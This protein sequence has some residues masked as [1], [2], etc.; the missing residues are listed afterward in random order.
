MHASQNERRTRTPSSFGKGLS[1][2]LCPNTERKNAP[3]LGLNWR[4]SGA[5]GA[6]Y[7]HPLAGLS[8]ERNIRDSFDWRTMEESLQIYLHRKNAMILAVYVDDIKEGKTQNMTNMWATLQNKVDLD[9][10]YDALI[11][12]ILD[13]LNGQ[14]KSITSFWWKKSIV[15]E[16]DQHRYRC[17]NW[18]EQ[19][20][21]HHSLE[22]RHGRSR[23]KVCWTPLRIGAQDDWLRHKISTHCLDD[24]Q[25]KPD[26]LENVGQLSERHAPDCI[27]RLILGKNRKTWSTLDGQLLCQIS[28][29][30]DPSMRSSTST[31]HQLLSSHNEWQ[32][33][34]SRWKSSNRL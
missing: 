26:E 14:H 31:C 4:S 21:K 22:L 19:S 24:H 28:H 13:V 12:K 33:V 30:V 18:R 10:Q 17:Q 23:S 29:K 9:D 32:T 11:K 5:A 1:N 3:T 20:Q 34:L 27:E 8:W 6:L 15:L 2:I 7:G 25:V 16:V